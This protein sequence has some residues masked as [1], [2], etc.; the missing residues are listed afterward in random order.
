MKEFLL[1]IWQIP[2]NLLG[3][4]LILF[5]R[6]KMY[7]EKEGR[8]FYHTPKMPSGISLGN[9]IILWRERYDNSFYHEY[10]HSRQSRMLGPLYL[11]IIG[12]PSILG[13]IFDRLAH[14]KWNYT[15]RL[16]WYYSQPWEKW[17][18]KLGN[19]QRFF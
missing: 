12:L 8:K 9:Y 17:A 14:K 2:Q 18:D 15:D 13:N 4:I 11:I 6:G 5:M 10:G 19:V 16:R 3:L 7:A 1:Y